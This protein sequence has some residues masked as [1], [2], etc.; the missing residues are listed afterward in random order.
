MIQD[1]AILANILVVLFFAV[2]MVLAYLAGRLH[3]NQRLQDQEPRTYGD[4]GGMPPL[5]EMAPCKPDTPAPD[6]GSGPLAGERPLQWTGH[7]PRRFTMQ[8]KAGDKPTP[9]THMEEES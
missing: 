2:A 3:A 6:D 1:P 7:P 8:G 4:N 5:H 9:M